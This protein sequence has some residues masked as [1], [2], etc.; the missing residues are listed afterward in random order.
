MRNELDFKDGNGCVCGV[1]GGAGGG[2][3]VV[4]EWSRP[5]G[6]PK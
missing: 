3:V 2:G 6:R 4:V 5:V 1:C